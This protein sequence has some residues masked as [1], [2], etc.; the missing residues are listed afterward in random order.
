MPKHPY[1]LCYKYH[2]N[3]PIIDHS[4]KE[5]RKVNRGIQYSGSKTLTL[6]HTQ[7]AD[8]LGALVA[9]PHKIRYIYAAPFIGLGGIDEYWTRYRLHKSAGL[10]LFLRAK[11]FSIMTNLLHF[12]VALENTR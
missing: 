1:L 10:T 8:N 6:I 4:F 3:I 12:V 11:Q 9:L 5:F 7:T 2:C